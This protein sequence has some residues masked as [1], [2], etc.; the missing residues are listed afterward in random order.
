MWLDYNRL[1]V[2]M[3][4]SG[5]A[6]EPVNLSSNVLFNPDGS[7]TLAGLKL[8]IFGKEYVKK[9]EKGE[10]TE[11]LLPLSGSVYDSGEGFL[12]LGAGPYDEIF[13][14]DGTQMR[15]LAEFNSLKSGISLTV[16]TDMPAVRFYTT[17]TPTAAAAFL[18]Q[19]VP[20]SGEKAVPVLSAGKEWKQRIIYGLDRVYDALRQ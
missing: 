14:S 18:G 4:A 11:E 9:D 17:S 13:V 15:P 10:Y 16:Y 12:T 3:T 20:G 1:V 8:R 7:D 2:D 5:D 19:F 6:E